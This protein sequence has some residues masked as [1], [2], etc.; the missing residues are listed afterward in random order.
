MMAFERN[1]FP[2]AMRIPVHFGDLYEQGMRHCS[3]ANRLCSSEPAE[4]YCLKAE[5]LSPIS[6]WTLYKNANSTGKNTLKNDL[7]IKLLW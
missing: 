2:V 5:A 7:A 3:I 6:S 4:N 1:P